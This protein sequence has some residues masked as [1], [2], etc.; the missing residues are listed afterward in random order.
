[1]HSGHQLAIA[2]W[3]MTGLSLVL[4]ILRLY[5]R[6]R[7][8]KFVGAE[9]YMYTLTGVSPLPH[10]IVSALMTSTAILTR[11]HSLHTDIGPLRTRP[12]LL[13]T[14][15]PELFR[16]YLL[17]LCREYLRNSWECNGQAVD[18]SLPTPCRPSTM[19]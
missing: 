17:D 8:V 9:D 16:C 4:V 1:M 18:G 7:I 2:M 3:G 13:A 19:A 14:Y 10:Y 12:K 5:T 15:H 11:L 6:I